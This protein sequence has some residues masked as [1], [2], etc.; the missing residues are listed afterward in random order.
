MFSTDFGLAFPQLNPYT[1]L[2][3]VLFDPTPFRLGGLPL[4]L[5]DR[6]GI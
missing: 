2:V 4:L 5:R 3:L 6:E 1:G